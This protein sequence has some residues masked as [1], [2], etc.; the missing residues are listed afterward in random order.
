M[1]APRTRPA[2]RGIRIGGVNGRHGGNNFIFRWRDGVDGGKGMAEGI[3]DH[4]LPGA[5]LVDNN[6]SVWGPVSFI[7]CTK[8]IKYKSR[9]Y[10]KYIIL[11]RTPP[12]AICPTLYPFIHIKIRLFK[13]L[14]S[15]NQSH[16][17]RS[18]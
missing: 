5:T 14:R 17:F 11:A 15:T 16:L 7:L 2:A 6:N 12:P 18:T 9:P 1:R 3:F 8:S 10:R 13:T 4:P